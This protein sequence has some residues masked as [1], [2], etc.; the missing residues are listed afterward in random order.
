MPV[1]GSQE[2]GC[3]SKRAQLLQRLEAGEAGD[4]RGSASWERGLR[5][6]APSRE[7]VL[8]TSAR[9]RGLSRAD[10]PFLL[11][12]WPMREGLRHKLFPSYSLWISREAPKVSDPLSWLGGGGAQNDCVGRVTSFL[13]PCPFPEPQ[14]LGKPQECV[15][16]TH[17]H[18]QTAHSGPGG[19]E[20]A[21]GS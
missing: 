10:V 4:P 7:V 12:E 16:G 1:P 11:E 20:P 6:P 15:G 19:Q 14:L 17:T 9:V 13:F 5:P 21:L 8:L 2:K 3:S 18:A